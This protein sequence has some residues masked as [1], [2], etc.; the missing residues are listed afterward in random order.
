MLL[1]VVTPVFSADPSYYFKKNTWQETMLVSREALIKAEQE[2]GG[3]SPLPD[4]GTSDFTISAWIKTSSDTASILARSITLGVWENQAKLFFI[5]SG[6]PAYAMGSSE[7]LDAEVIVNDDRW[8]HVVVTG[9]NPLVFYVDGEL[10]KEHL[11]PESVRIEPDNPGHN[12]TI[13]WCSL[14]FPQRMRGFV[15]SIDEVRIYNRRL[16]REE[17]NNLFRDP[18]SVNDGV[19]GWWRFEEQAVDSSENFNDGQITSAVVSEGKFGKALYFHGLAGVG[20]PFVPGGNTR[21]KITEL[22]IRD[23]SDDLSQKEIQWENEDNIWQDDWK[24]GDLKE[25]GSRYAKACKDLIGLPGKTNQLVQNITSMADLSAVREIYHFSRLSDDRYKTVHDKSNLMVEEINYLQELHSK[26]DS[27]WNRYKQSVAE[28]SGSSKKLLSKIDEGDESALMTLSEQLNEL[29]NVHGTIPHEMPSGPAGPVRFGAI[30]KKL[31]YTLEWDKPWRVGEDTDVVVQFDDDSHRLVFWRGTSYIPCWVNDAGKWY[32]NEFVERRG[33]HS[34]NTQGSVEPMSDK[35]CRLSHV[36][37]IENN[38]ARVVVHWR[39]A[40]I[41][42]YYEYPFTDPETGWSDWVD[43]YY[44]IYPDA[45]CIRKIT[46]HSSRVD[47]WM[48]FQE[49]ILLNQPGTLP[50]D[51]IELDAVS[52][53]NMKGETFT[54]LW[55]ED[56]GPDFGKPTRA[57][58]L[59]INL[60]GKLKPFAFVAPAEDDGKLITTYKGHNPLSHFNFWD[61]WPVSQYASAGRGA[62]SAKRPSHSSLCHIALPGTA[63][64]EWLLYDQGENWVTKLMANG[65]TDKPIADLVPLAKSWL[66]AA[67]LKISGSAFSSRGYDQTQA[68]YIIV[69]KEMNKPTTL[70]FELTASKESPI[71]NP[72]FVIK[73][74]GEKGA[75]LKLNGKKIKNRKDFRFG[76]RNYSQSSDL[77][78]WIRTA[79]ITPIKITLSPLA[80]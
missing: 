42:V 66:N 6:K 32:T 67:K 37:I 46:A 15:G 63:E 77:I 27:E 11:I 17:V 5:R 12:L 57:N 36:R 43:E 30:Y 13:G 72:A 31:K 70:T 19:S 7:I 20:L 25:L 74:W 38:N 23:F 55:T 28:V 52:L 35:Q 21:N 24:P 41:D 47:L 8:H 79:S 60:K 9:G 69:L 26:D 50:E 16:S 71:I 53:A 40:P 10:A 78:V 39:Y 2:P 33:W 75:T 65:L 64:T 49:S 76:H 73:N 48:E 62:I 22:I 51:N 34:P 4:F 44:T 29:E 18:R 54:Y 61:H 14:N 58:I 68:A 45:F 56:G 1:S 80:N 59:K 3:P